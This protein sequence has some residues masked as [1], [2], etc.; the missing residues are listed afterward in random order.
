MPICAL[1]YGGTHHPEVFEEYKNACLQS[2]SKVDEVP[3]EDIE[4]TAEIPPVDDGL[5]TIRFRWEDLLEHFDLQ[6]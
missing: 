1:F 4:V 2:S 5:V 3:V 6:M